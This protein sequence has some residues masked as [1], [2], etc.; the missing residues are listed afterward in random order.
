MRSGRIAGM[1]DPA[2]LRA[3]MA[4]LGQ[5]AYRATQVYRAL[6]QGLAT[7]FAAIGVCRRRCAPPWPNAFSPFR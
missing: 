5:P 1:I 4:E 2:V 6:T 3:T 7:D